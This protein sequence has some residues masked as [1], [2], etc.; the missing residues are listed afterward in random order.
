RLVLHFESRLTKIV[1][2]FQDYTALKLLRVPRGFCEETRHKA[3][4]VKR[5]E[6]GLVDPTE[7]TSGEVA[8]AC[9][10]IKALDALQFYRIVLEIVVNNVEDVG[11]EGMRQFAHT[12]QKFRYGLDLQPLPPKAR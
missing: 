11:S 9:N 12:S 3:V 10:R 1:S 8:P 7:S 6:K 5:L 2:H 4:F